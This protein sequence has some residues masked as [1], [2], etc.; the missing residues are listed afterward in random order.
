MGAVNDHTLWDSVQKGLF[1]CL[2]LVSLHHVDSC[3]KRWFLETVEFC[4]H[5]RHQP[6][7]TMDLKG[8]TGSLRQVSG[9][10]TY[11][12]GICFDMEVQS[13]MTLHMSIQK[14]SLK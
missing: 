1:L 2:S 8:A 14:Q 13:H 7:E 3:C 4:G 6:Q 10:C 11:F 5:L 9:I 12:V